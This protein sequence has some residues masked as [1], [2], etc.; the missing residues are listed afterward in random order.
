[1]AQQPAPVGLFVYFVYSVPKSSG[2]YTHEIPVDAM[3]FTQ[4]SV[5]LLPHVLKA[6]AIQSDRQNT[7]VLHI[8]LPMCISNF[9]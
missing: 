3:V 4:F 8:K 2:L 7:G 6:H 5:D 9:V 1:M